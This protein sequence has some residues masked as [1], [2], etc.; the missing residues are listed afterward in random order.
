MLPAIGDRTPIEQWAGLRP[1]S[2]DRLPLLGPEPELPGLFYATGYGRDG[3]LI[4]DLAGRIVAD[5]V[6]A[7]ESEL[8]WRPFR[9]ERFSGAAS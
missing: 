6:L 7:G 1:L 8:D 4:A 5:L 2:A 3:I 9:P